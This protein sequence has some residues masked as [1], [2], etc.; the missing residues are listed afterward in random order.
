MLDCADLKKTMCEKA[1]EHVSMLQAA[2]AA[3]NAEV[4]QKMCTEYSEIRAR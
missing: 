4:M 1:E 3:D 2:V